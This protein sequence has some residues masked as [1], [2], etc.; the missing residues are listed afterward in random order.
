M[1]DPTLNPEPNEKGSIHRPT[2]LIPFRFKSSYGQGSFSFERDEWKIS[3]G[4]NNNKKRERNNRSGEEDFRKCSSN[5]HTVSQPIHIYFSKRIDL[6]FCPP[7]KKQKWII[8]D[9]TKKKSIYR[10]THSICP[11]PYQVLHYSVKETV[12]W[13]YLTN[14]KK[15]CHQQFSKGWVA[16]YLNRTKASK[17]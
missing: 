16:T 4:W 2:R 3:P 7:T 1:D 13:R 15:R 14:E 8:K 5:E 6:I 11:L 12:S 17:R 10:T 9:R